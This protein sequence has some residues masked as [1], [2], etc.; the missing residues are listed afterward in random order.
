MDVFADMA[1]KIIEHQEKIIGPVAVEQAQSIAGLTLDWVKKEASFTGEPKQVLN[2]L[3][4]QYQY[5]FGQIS[6]EVCKEAIRGVM[7]QVSHDQ[8]PELL[9]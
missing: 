2:E 9:Q 3:V 6:V 7:G 4:S 1:V 8:L 5:L